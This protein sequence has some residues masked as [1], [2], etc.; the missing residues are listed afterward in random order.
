MVK[1]FIS[2]LAFAML[3]ACMPQPIIKQTVVKEEI[4]IYVVPKPP[5]ISPRP[6]LEISKLTDEDKKN[7]ALVAKALSVSLEQ[8]KDY[9]GDLEAVY[10][11]YMELSNTSVTV[12]NFN[13]KTPALLSIDKLKEFLDQGKKK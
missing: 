10:N 1:V 7:I 5:A 13:P 11:K 4:P 6:V 2:I 12:D 8:L 3:T 9:S